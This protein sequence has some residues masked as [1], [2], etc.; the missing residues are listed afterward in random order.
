MDEL[1]LAVSYVSAWMFCLPDVV[2]LDALPDEDEGERQEELTPLG[3]VAADRHTRGHLACC[4]EDA[5]EG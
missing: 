3:E 2:L 4:L 1:E 5:I